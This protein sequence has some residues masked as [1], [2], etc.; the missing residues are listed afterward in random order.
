MADE[1]TGFALGE[2]AEAFQGAL[3]PTLNYRIARAQQQL[4]VGMQKERLA[5]DKEKQAISIQALQQDMQTQAIEQ[6]T[7]EEELKD[8]VHK[9]ELARESDKLINI[10]KQFP[11]SEGAKKKEKGAPRAGQ[12][13]AAFQQDDFDDEKLLEA[14]NL[15]GRSAPLSL[16]KRVA[17]KAITPHEREMRRLD[18]ESEE[19]LIEQRK[20]AAAASRRPKA[21][22]GTLT[23][24]DRARL[25]DPNISE[26]EKVLIRQSL[27][28]NKTTVN[29]VPMEEIESMLDKSYPVGLGGIRAGLPP[30]LRD[31]PIAMYRHG[32]ELV[33]ELR[34]QIPS[35]IPETDDQ[36][37][38]GTGGSRY[39]D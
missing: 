10:V 35:V 18:I 33:N 13:F 26:D 28:G 27:F 30:E 9:G 32:A 14:Y 15:A 24:R 31:D 39:F 7:A 22:A 36:L 1:G 38:T 20:A 3:F 17:E 4:Q 8:K 25:L 34:G 37:D 29:G 6:R 21:A 5:M 23:E 11:V 19:S 16:Q 12:P 2:G